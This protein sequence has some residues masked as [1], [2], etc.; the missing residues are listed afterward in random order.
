MNGSRRRQSKA[1]WSSSSARARRGWR[2]RSL[3]PLEPRALLAARPVDLIDPSLAGLSGLKASSVPSISAD[4]Q[5]VAF[6]SDADNLVPNDADNHTDAFVYDRGT[7]AVTLVSVGSNGQAAG[8]DGFT[9]SMGP[10][11]SPDGR[12]VVFENNAGNVLPGVSG[13]QLY[14]RDLAKGT[15][16]LLT[17]AANGTGGG[18][19]SSRHPVFS[20][21]GHHI[22][23]I[24]GASNLV[25]G[26]TFTSP[27]RDNVFERDLVTG[28]TSLVSASLDGKSDGNASSGTV[29]LGS[30][31]I[32]LS[33]DGR[34]VAFGTTASNLVSLSNTG[35]D[36]V[37]V[38]DT[39][40]STTT[41]VSVDITG[42]AGGAGHNKLDANSQI[43]SADG[44]YVVFHSNATDLTTPPPSGTEVYLRDLRTGTT[45]L[46][47]ASAVDGHS[48][49]SPGSE[50][51]SPDGR[52]AAFATA[53]SN[54][55]AMPTNG[56][57]NV[58]VRNIQTGVLSLVS[59]NAAGTGGGNAGSGIGTFFDEPGGLSFSPDGRYL[60]FRSKATDL[61]P[62]VVTGN[63][64]LYV[65][66]LDAGRT[67]LVTPN[68]ARTDGGAGDADTVASVV[69]SADGRSVAFEDTADDLVPGDT[70]RDGQGKPV[71]DVFVCDLSA[72]T[73]ALASLRTPLL[74]AAVTTQTGAQLTTSFA[75][76]SPA[77]FESV[78]ADGRYIAFTSTGSGNTFSDLAPGVTISSALTGTHVFVRDR[79]TGTIRV[80]D[81]D[82]S[83]TAAGGLDPVITPDGRYVAFIGYTNLLPAGVA[84]SDGHD[85]EVYVRDL[86]AN[87][88]S[89]VSLDPTGTHDAPVDARE[90]AISADGRY[91]AWSSV[92][93][94]AVAGTTSATPGGDE[95]IFLRD[96]QAGTNYL[97]SHDLANDGQ[98][99]GSS[100]D[101]SLSA[102]GR[103]ALFT[104]TDPNLAANDTNNEPD[105]FRWD[106]STNQVALVSVNAAGTGPGNGNSDQGFA[107]VMSA[108]GRFIAFTSNATNLVAGGTPGENVFLRDMGDGTAPP[109]TKLVSVN[110]AGTGAGN[111][112]SWGPS[113][114]ADGSL[115]AFAS[116][117]SDLTAIPDQNNTT[118]VFVRNMATGRTTLASLNVAGTAPA[119]PF[120][121]TSH[122][123]VLSPGGRYVA[124]L[125]VATD[126]VPGYVS[127]N[128]GSFDLYLRDLQQGTTRL[129][130][131]NQSGTAGGNRDQASQPVIFGGDGTLAFSSN[132][133]DLYPGDR[134]NGTDVFAVATAGFSGLGGQVFN[135]LNG[136]GAD[137]SEPGLP[138]WTI[139][140][141]ANK[142]GR[143]DP[144]E[145]SVITDASG[146]YA[147]NDLPPGTYTVAAVP[148]SGYTQTTPSS[149]TVTITAD[150]QAV[151][152]KDFGEVRL[153][154]DLAASGVAF[155]PASAGPGQPVTV[156][157]QVA[158]SGRGAAAGSWVDAIYLSPT[159]TLGPD[160]RLFTTVPHG[161]GLAAGQSYSGS[162]T[163]ALPP[164]PQGTDYVI[165]QADW[166]NQVNEGSFGANKANNIAASSS[167]L[168]VTVPALTPGV[169]TQG[170]FTGPGQGLYYQIS[171]TAGQTLHL[172]LTSAAGS[173]ADE[174]YVRRGAYP[175]PS[176]FDFAARVAG[177]PNQSL[178]IP[179]TAGG[180]YFVEARP[181]S[182][183]ASTAGFTLVASLPTFRITSL[184]LTSGGNTGRVTVPILGALLTPNTQASLVSGGTVIPA[185]TVYYQDAS[186]IFATFDLTG[187]APGA[188]DVRLQDVNQSATLPGAFSIVP[189]L[190]VAPQITLA[191]PS[192]VRA[193]GSDG[194]IVR[195]VNT[196]NTDV[197]APLIGVTADHALF[198]LPD[199]PN[200]LVGTIQVL[201][202]SADGPAGILRP[203]EGGQLTIPFRSTAAAGQDIHFSTSIADDSAPMNWAPLKASLKMDH[204][205]SDAWD[206][207]YANFTANVGATV[208]SY[209]AALAAD[210]TYLSQLGEPT[211]DVSRLLSFEFN[212]A[213]G[214]F[215]AQTLATV[216]DASFPAP[217]LPLAFVRQFQQSLS[218]RFTIG[219]FGRGWTD[220][221]QISAEADAQGNVEVHEGGFGRFFARQ[222][223]GSFKGTE[224][225]LATLGL[226]DGAYR[227]VETDGTVLAFN[228]DGTLNYE[229]DANGNRITA[230]YTAGRLTGL[231]HSDGQAIAIHYNAQGLIDQVT[232]PAGRV[233][234][235]VYDPTGQYLT[236]YTDKYGTTR[237]SYM[238]GQADPA[239]NNALTQIAY[240]DNTHIVYG[241]D[242]QGRLIDQHRDN[243]QED[244]GYA[245]GP[246]GGYTL[247][248]AD[249][250]KTTY[251]IDDSGNVAE[252]VDPLGD[253]TRYSYDA[254]QN[255]TQVSAPL[256]ATYSYTYN[257]QGDLT[258]STD[259]L[260]NVVSFSYDAQH[261]LLGYTD[262]KNHATKYGVDGSGNLL[263]ITYADGN[264]TQFQ[265]DPLGN[266]T[267]TIDARGQALQ[268]KYDA[269][270]L[271]LQ[272]T[273]P[274]NS[275][276]TY[277]YDTHGNLF[278]A[279]DQAGNL[280]TLHYDAADNLD[281]IDYPGGRFLKFLYNT[282]GQRKQSVD[283]TGFKVTYDYDALG[284]LCDLT[285]GSK[286]LIVEYTYDPA[287]RLIEKDLGNGTYTTYQYDQAGNLLHLV[288]HA[289]HPAPGQDGP[290]NSE[291]DYTYDALGR[292]TTET[293][294]DGQWVYTYDADGQLT[295]AVFTPNASS[296]VPA[297]DLQYTYDAAGNRTQTVINGVTTA[298]T[299]NNVNEY[300]QVGGTTYTYDPDG[301]LATA[302]TGGVTTTYTFD[303]ENQLTGITSPSDTWA[304]QYDPFGNRI[305]TTHNGATTQNLIDPGGLGNIVAQYDGSGNL[306]AHYTYGL[307]LVSQVAASG[308]AGYYDDDLTGD[309]AGITGASGAYVNRYT[310][311]PFGQI[312]ASSVGVSNPFTFVGQSGV[313][314]DGSGLLD[315]RARSYDPA[316]GQFASV[317]PLGLAGS[318]TNLRAYVANSPT[319]AIDPTGLCKYNT[320]N[321]KSKPQLGGTFKGKDWGPNNLGIGPNLKFE[322]SPG[323]FNNYGIVDEDD[324]YWYAK[325]FNG[326]VFHQ[327]KK[328][329]PPNASGGG[330]AGG[331]LPAGGPAPHSS[332][333]PEGGKSGCPCGCP[334]DNSPGPKGKNGPFGTCKSPG[335]IDPNEL[336]GPA[337]VGPQGYVTGQPVLPYTIGF[338]NDPAKATLAAQ[339]VTVT[340]PLSPNLDWST[341]QL[342]DIQF[343]ATIIPVPAGLQSFSTTVDATNVDGTPLRVAI[344][345][346]LDAQAGVVTWTFTSLD[347]ATG[348][349]PTSLVAGFL[350]VD[351]STGRGQGFVHFSVLPNAGLAT[352]AAIQA[353]ATVVFDTNPALATNAVVNTIDVTPPTSRVAALAP[354]EHRSAFAVSWSGS[355]AGS[356]VATYDVYVSTNGGPF[357]PWLTGTAATSAV[358]VGKVG[359]SY[360]F[361]SIAR[362]LVGN[363]QP[364]PTALA[365]T[366]VIPGAAANDFDGDG[367][368]DL[369]V[370]RPTT[371]QWIIAQSGGGVRVV[372][373][374]APRTDV[375][376]V[377]DF[378]GDGKADFAVY[379]PTTGQWIILR[380]SAGPEVI[381]FGA[382]N[383]DIPVPADYDGDGKTD[384]AVYRPST[385]QWIILRSTLGPEVV[386]LGAPGDIPVP[387]DY[388]GDGK[389]DIA[390]YRPTTGQWLILRSG[391]GPRVVSFGLKGVDVPV[392]AD[393]DGDGKADLAV[394]RPTTGQWLILR[395]TAG[396][397][398]VRLGTPD[399]DIP[400]PADYDGDGKADIAVYRKTTGQWIIL[401]SSA[402]GRIA[403]FGAPNVDVPVPTPLAYRYKGGLVRGAGLDGPMVAAAPAPVVQGE[404]AAA[405]PVAPAS[406]YD[407][408]LASWTPSRRRSRRGG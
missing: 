116:H 400:V 69:F 303:Q 3:E 331:S 146:H 4:G 19:Y 158:N 55:V 239:L 263:S 397:E 66:D 5:L 90:L 359:Q 378:D 383:T 363:L 390:V 334:P 323:R 169:P 382:P 338:E 221:W 293:T 371:G 273:Y 302:T 248:D 254:N 176:D 38:R 348:Q 374:G 284:R 16:T 283:Q 250:G 343:G 94:R 132:D 194:V 161:G 228:A 233:S 44:R 114:S 79:L 287:G 269:N 31:A 299:V 120:G 168:G 113:I 99:R 11:I 33:A 251:L 277:Q 357:T 135:D 310:Y 241:Y 105:V 335:A 285:D 213:A 71:N 14:L 63:R 280:T 315:M 56:Q 386:R 245:Y 50:V 61:T 144:G 356:G 186:H 162:T 139:F 305:S 367:K 123:P 257:S 182:G 129:V 190:S 175:D 127:A 85:L 290:V 246:A 270:G 164:V 244:V 76:A 46:L 318:G 157:W 340:L 369:A 387:A 74:P 295:H 9:N 304:Y 20:A 84:T 58:Y 220:N 268:Y 73:T 140:L 95:M 174:L 10:A 375:P 137:D 134:N 156:T 261:H 362:D 292:A 312:V 389:A 54:V 384:L 51:I 327:S 314:G 21:D 296:S 41:M 92:D 125:S 404:R 230:T 78:S 170:A 103:Y 227:L 232:D 24:S 165:V 7:G 184:G 191:V 172:A 237:Y 249:G 373:L 18:N 163:L 98:V 355:D 300:T 42:Q 286:N 142:N 115:V 321:T 320:S 204:I 124:F 53:S 264:G 70:N 43:I 402:G 301:N 100:H 396:P 171:V 274:D 40:A 346:G 65:R 247:T 206:A 211:P 48:V 223:D 215:T 179:T 271:L 88:T 200:L 147:F 214:T 407:E 282:V 313:T 91:V 260:G 358:F 17:A 149:Y 208:G 385:G 160:A 376:L 150:G 152:G 167:T 32:G 351:D 231:K 316:T 136:N 198:H 126:L 155:S 252:T 222:P 408:V 388:D 6:A 353:Q 35:I 109:A 49:G 298:Y 22:A 106:R 107:P 181:V 23:F 265:Y 235:Y 117:A 288:N 309:T 27:G 377:G 195:Y 151:T 111:G 337:G 143:L 398:V 279:K 272:K 275:T 329:D 281:E 202:I 101:L 238:T 347:P 180:T 15:T 234:S 349:P 118:N 77:N 187:R 159:P 403:A 82:P 93:T 216:V 178:D 8:I 262:A 360:R 242:A 243:N 87:T 393:Y 203:G 119:G 297:Q 368:A 328:G 121:A 364:A 365:T 325:D 81:V 173:G 153:L 372:P 177:Q 26:V 45:V 342:G 229:Q 391:A 317:D 394:Y 57:A 83:G 201:G 1:P 236:S 381:K 39:V 344:T 278:Q 219:P 218:G 148:Q 405:M 128:N 401:Q 207:I 256:G 354:V 108:D 332:T 52:F 370:Y 133:S 326:D 112:N 399:I 307:S 308:S 266:L 28:V 258:S 67:L 193:G 141:D 131:V 224:G 406:A 60:A 289:P 341:F 12:Y 96:R 240:S 253:V 102:D 212:K 259:P 2:A 311:V 30:D 395:S 138:Y 188:Y 352:N 59:V 189:G 75:D 13:D 104:S 145:E 379:R 226:V 197:L 339:A 210:A 306:I 37:Y 345:A 47:S 322:E 336:I 72:G 80:V 276:V 209:H 97:V 255:L 154:P 34:Y 122:A 205:P 361:Y 291:F 86:Q 217:G 330:D 110:L 324:D 192:V 166:R 350:P 392:P 380:S 366:R 196:G 29:S 183:A 199:E 68:L 64:N 130:S 185:A 25:T 319:G 333:P 62:G 36:Q 294:S 225:D 89:V 267:E